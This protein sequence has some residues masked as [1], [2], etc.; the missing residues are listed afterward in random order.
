MMRCII[1]DVM[2]G[3]KKN[4]G[5]VAVL[6]ALVFTFLFVLFAMVIDFGHLINAKMNLQI[7]ADMAAYAGAAWQARTLNK[8]AMINYK[9]RQDF[10]EFA[11]RTQVTHLRHNR[12]FPRG[13]NFINGGDR[14]HNT[15]PF[16]CQQAHGYVALSGL[17]YKNDTNLCRNASPSV[18]GLP[19]IVVPPVIATFD[20]FA[21]AIAAQIRRIADASN[22]ECRAAAID[23]RVL[24]QHLINVYTRRSH[25]H[26][27]QA[28]AIVDWLN[29]IG[30]GKIDS[31]DNHPINRIAYKSAWN[32]L[33]LANKD[34]FEMEV[35]IPSGG[36]YLTIIPYKAN[37][38]LFYVNFNVVGDGCVG[39]PSF[40]DFNDM[41][42][43]FEKD[44]SIVTYYAVKLTSRPRM[45]F[46]PQNWIDNEFPKLEVY[47]VAKP[48]GS[49]LG[50]DSAGDQLLPVPNRPGN[51][52]R[53]LNF[54][55]KINDQLGIMNT[56]VMAYLDAL[57]PFNSAG[58]PDGNQ[59]TGWPDPLKA[60]NLRTPL[61]AIRA[62]TIFDSAFY[63]IFPDPNRSN[64][65]FES[66]YAMSL[67]PD[68]LEASDINNQIIST[69]EP[70]TDP[71]FPDS[72]GPAISRG[73]GWIAVSAPQ[74]LATGPN[75]GSYAAEAPSSHSV[76]LA[77][78]LPLLS[79]EKVNEFGWANKN[80]L[81]S[82]WAP[83]GRYRIGYS[84]KFISF[85]ALLR[86]QVRQK[87][88]NT[89]GPIA[90][91]PE[92]ED[93]LLMILH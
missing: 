37:A 32:N 12:N 51:A 38:T 80:Q 41:V 65:Y 6:F 72:V 35:L 42:V 79:E 90:N 16:I 70:A 3:G 30:G 5:Q 45:M 34:D 46:M 28:L 4:G 44:K 56:K 64:D 77:T 68:Y 27:K 20:P 67:Y 43:G 53:M 39:R 24:S 13:T 59:S 61:Q 17:R 86:L 47:S 7:A 73:I 23:N 75:Y 54:S 8:L 71:Y 10:K 1:K 81:H 48:F 69:P 52:N 49:R 14:A 89:V 66:D 33:S 50:P 2:G 91:P 36:N 62:P 88:T 58:R 82:G 25:F 29:S 83:L 93:N 63:T 84:V 40:I 57:H 78:G 60:V 55:F 85:D 11:M 31:D 22:Q 9:L 26:E 76:T 19:P 87:G 92:G 21:L 74:N 15:E 18:G